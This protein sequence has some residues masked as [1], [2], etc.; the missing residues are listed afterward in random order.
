M[1]I[2]SPQLGE[3]MDL[4]EEQAAAAIRQLR[5]QRDEARAVLSDCESAARGERAVQFSGGILVS[6]ARLDEALLDAAA[7]NRTLE[8]QRDEA[9]AKVERIERAHLRL[10]PYLNHGPGCSSRSAAM[11]PCDC[12][13]ADL[14]RDEEEK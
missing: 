9:R 11:T 13:L 6:K 8:K 2:D 12:L 3:V 14:L 5:R 1:A 10:L 4:T 7:E